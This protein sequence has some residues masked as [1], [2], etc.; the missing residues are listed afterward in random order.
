MVVSREKS[1]VFL[2]GNIVELHVSTGEERWQLYYSFA[3][4][5]TFCAQL[6]CRVCNKNGVGIRIFIYS[7]LLLLHYYSDYIHV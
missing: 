3:P 1:S 7:Y 4:I 6:E 5:P 2:V